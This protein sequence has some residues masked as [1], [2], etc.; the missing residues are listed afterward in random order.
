M[1]GE[2]DDALA[3]LERWDEVRRQLNHGANGAE[4][5]LDEVVRAVMPVLT[6]RGTG[7][8]TLTISVA[9][10]S[11]AIEL[12]ARDGTV[13]TST[14]VE[15]NGSASARPSRSAARLAEMIRQ[16]PSLLDG[17]RAGNDPPS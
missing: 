2:L 17:L 14:P 9:G 11:S 3:R 6:R 8:V 16:N 13:H 15:T 4:A 12:T 1:R 10:G 5:L 7:T